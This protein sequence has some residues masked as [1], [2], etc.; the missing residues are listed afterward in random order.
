MDLASITS[1]RAWVCSTG[2]MRKWNIW[3][4]NDA[5]QGAEVPKDRL[6][7]PG[8]PVFHHSSFP[9]VVFFLGRDFN[10]NSA[11]TMAMVRNAIGRTL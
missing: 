11:S 4:N 2:A 7:I 3:E 9:R 5:R 8:I 1:Q 6:S 10:K